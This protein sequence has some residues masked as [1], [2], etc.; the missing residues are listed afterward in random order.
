MFY[1]NICIVKMNNALHFVFAYYYLYLHI[2]L[3][4]LKKLKFYITRLI[5]LFHPR[6]NHMNFCIDTCKVLLHSFWLYD[7][8]IPLQ[9][10]FFLFLHIK[11]ENHFSVQT[12]HDN[13]TNWLLWNACVSNCILYFALLGAWFWNIKKTLDFFL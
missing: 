12:K 7:D 13:K 3:C 1:S 9:S 8:V 2:I 5:P 10:N 11:H 4:F 6:Y